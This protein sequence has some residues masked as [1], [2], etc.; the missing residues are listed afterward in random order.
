[1]QIVSDFQYDRHL[2]RQCAGATDVLLGNAG[3]VQTVEHAK[4][5]EHFPACSQE[6]DS[7]ELVDLIFGNNIEVRA[8]IFAG[9][10]GPENLF[11]SQGARS[12]PFW[13]GYF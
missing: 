6:R 12:N 9:L 4:H 5:A 13:E 3:A 1:M 8:L 2:I 7:Q 11:R 10:V